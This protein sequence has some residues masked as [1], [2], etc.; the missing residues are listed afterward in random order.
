DLS[1]KSSVETNLS[2]LLPISV[3]EYFLMRRLA[4]AL[5]AATC[6]GCQ[7]SNEIPLVDFP[8]GAPA[9]PPES[10][11]KNKSPEGNNTSRPD[12]STNPR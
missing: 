3:Q 4:L 1:S 5:I 10:K 2:P 9:P 7:Q 8:K 12:P 6:I 11:D